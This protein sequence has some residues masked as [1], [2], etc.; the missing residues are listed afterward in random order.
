MMRIV[1]RVI[2]V[3]VALAVVMTAALAFQFVANGQIGALLSIGIFGLL[4][5][6][7]W[8]LTILVGPF[9]AVQ[10]WRHRPSGRRATV[11]LAAFGAFYYLSGLLVF[12]SPGT[13]TTVVVLMV[14][15]HA[16][17]LA[18]LLTAAARSQCRVGASP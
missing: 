18:F 12:R 13:N 16:A 15:I 8:M 3:L 11:V 4:T 10:L 6:T 1:L 7:S 5:L 9:A 14:A 17:V 2:S